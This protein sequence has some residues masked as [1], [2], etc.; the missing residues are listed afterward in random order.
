MT[1][2]TGGEFTAMQ[3]RSTGATSANILLAGQVITT[4]VTLTDSD[5]TPSVIG[6]DSFVSNTTGVTITRF[7]DCTTGQE[8][9]IISKGVI[10]YD[11]TTNARLLGSSVDITTASGDVTRWIC[12]TGGTTGSICH[13][14][15]F[16]D[17]S[18]DNSSGI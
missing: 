9:S 7:D 10:V 12:E 16:V 1:H 5:T 3:V 4:P 11:T 15:S 6:S 8:F 14:L 17:I 2:D 18:A 13:L